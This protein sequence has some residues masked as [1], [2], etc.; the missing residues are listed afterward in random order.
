VLLPLA[1][2]GAAAGIAWK[3]AF[4][5]AEADLSR[6]AD[7][8][9]EYG[10]RVL[11]GYRAVVDRANDLLRGLNDEEIRAREAELHA[12][13]RRRVQETP[14]L[15]TSYVADRH[16]RLLLSASVMPVPRDRDFSD[17]EF[18]NLLAVPEAPPAVVTRIY[19]GRVESNVFFAVARRRTGSGNPD[20]PQGGFDGQVNVA[21]DPE[22]LSDGLRRIAAGP[23]DVLT[24]ARADGYVLARSAGFGDLPPTRPVAASSPLLAAA[25]AGAERATSTTPSTVDGV[26][27]HTHYRRLEGWPVYAVAAR[28]RAAI[29]ARWQRAVMPLAF[30]GL[31][32]SAL[33]TAL[34]LVVLRRQRQLA[35]LNDA[36][37][38]RVADRTAALAASEA[39]FRAT[40]E[41]SP[42][43]L[44]Q[45]D[46]ATG[47]FVRANAAFSAL[48][49]L[50]EAE[51]LGGMSAAD[52]THPEDRAADAVRFR[53]TVTTGAR[54]TIEKRYVLRDGRV[55]W[56]QVSSGLIRDSA[57]RALRTIAS[58]QDVTARKQAEERLLL[59]AREVDHRA[60]NV[61]AVVQA[62]LRLAP[63]SDPEAF[64][65]AVE[66]RIAAL[67][68]AQVVL[69]EANWRGAE[70]RLLA[71]GALAAFATQGGTRLSGPP[72]LL[73]AVAVQ[74]I[75]L[76]LHELATNASKYGALSVPDGQV[77]LSWDL[78]EAA[79]VLAL[80]WAE[81]GGPPAAAP[82]RRG[83]GSRVVDATMQDQLGGRVERRW[84]ATG[85]TCTITL[86]V[87]RAVSRD[88][89][90]AE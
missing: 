40:F 61:M 21:V 84:E 79:G 81:T 13:L 30:V 4:A 59:L 73:A 26:V 10:R 15:Q 12:E 8:A 46:P 3:Q 74:P 38:A 31:A 9:A 24:L 43:A 71:E 83:F 89:F 57:G 52:L 75:S 76:A 14:E 17:R 67:A 49:G 28:P 19:V 41:D 86:P 90:L 16:G 69:S 45:S 53:A 11:D 63:R 39:D 87:A 35:R 56:V 47:R 22:T 42:V 70:L 32:A 65:R 64:V 36:L 58:V 85:L 29:V 37:E 27:R 6:A 80:R 5:E 50:S 7:V 66:G 23:E 62:A 55:I 1:I 60:K 25:R 54:H 88:L 68:R 72:V 44:V 48:T 34:A 51:L 18:H 20:L 77:D 2:S 82:A 78:D 33:L